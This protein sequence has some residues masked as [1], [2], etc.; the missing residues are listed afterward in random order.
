MEAIMLRDALPFILADSIIT[1][2]PE[3]KLIQQE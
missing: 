2:N 3:I 1:D